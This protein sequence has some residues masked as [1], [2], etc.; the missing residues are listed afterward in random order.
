M[1]IGIAGIGVVGGFGCGHPALLR[2]LKKGSAETAWKTIRTA[3]GDMEVPAL[4]ADTSALADYVPLRTLRRNDHYTR[5]ALLG[6][7]LALEDAKISPGE[8]LHR[9][10]IIVATGLG[11]TCNTL[12]F[13]DIMSGKNAVCSPTLFSNSVHNAAAAHISIFLKSGGPNLSVNQY[14]LSVPSAFMTACH[15]LR[16]ERTD[17]VLL[18]G[19]DEFSKVGAYYRFNCEKSGKSG[20]SSLPVGEGCAFF[21]LTSDPEKIRY[22]YIEDAFAGICPAETMEDRGLHPLMNG[23]SRCG[24]L[25][26]SGVSGDVCSTPLQEKSGDLPRCPVEMR[27]NTILMC[28]RETYEK[29]AAT[30]RTKKTARK[31]DTAISCS[32]LY[33]SLPVAMA[34]DIAA[35]GLII[36]EGIRNLPADLFLHS[37]GDI[38]PA[39]PVC[40]LK[41]RENN[42]LGFV[43]LL[44]LHPLFPAKKGVKV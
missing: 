3:G 27:E 24:G 16:E 38:S 43:R 29:A 26:L 31:A 10:G 19:V 18:G 17:T 36:K 15:W 42:E 41:I 30:L 14:E 35:A 13:E 22:G 4:C 2:A 39:A 1:R 37:P 25:P 12:D 20:K 21:I 5:M 32:R 40:C 6:S 44:P 23:I 33:G 7:F 34:F 11:S 8:D 28:D 9:M